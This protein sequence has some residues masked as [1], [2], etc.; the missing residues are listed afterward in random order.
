LSPPSSSTFNPHSRLAADST[1]SF[2]GDYKASWI[3]GASR[4][5]V[6]GGYGTQGGNSFRSAPFTAADSTALPPNTSNVSPAVSVADRD[7]W[8]FPGDVSASAS[9]KKPSMFAANPWES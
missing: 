9:V 4:K 6:F 3:P 5:D 8:S 1:L 2:K 7:P